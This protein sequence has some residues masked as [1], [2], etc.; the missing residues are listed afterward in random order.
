MS[1]SKIGQEL[2]GNRVFVKKSLNHRHRT[3]FVRVVHRDDDHWALIRRS[4]E[5]QASNDKI[6]FLVMVT[7]DEEQFLD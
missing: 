2:Y 5:L 1:L 7:N 4:K 6:R 3:W